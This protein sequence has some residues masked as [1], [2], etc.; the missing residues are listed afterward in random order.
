[1][2]TVFG[3]LGAGFPAGKSV[4]PVLPLRGH[5]GCIGLTRS[6]ARRCFNQNFRRRDLTGPEVS[7]IE[8]KLL[9]TLREGQGR[10]DVHGLREDPPV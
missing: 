8:Q 3:V 4:P 1:M 9:P 2:L 5:G 10:R 6:V 7:Q